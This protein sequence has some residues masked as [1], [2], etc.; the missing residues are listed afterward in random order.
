MNERVTETDALQRFPELAELVA[1]HEARWNFHLLGE[2]DTV[3]G[4]AASPRPVHRCPV[5]LP[6][7]AH[8][9]EPIG[10]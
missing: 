6:P 10:P 5:H 1:I 8:L 7:H 3:V 4:I 9:G 2:N